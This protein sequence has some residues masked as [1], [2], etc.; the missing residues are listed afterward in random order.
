MA[1]WT[2]PTLEGLT[3]NKEPH[4][5]RLVLQVRPAEGEAESAQSEAGPRTRIFPGNTLAAPAAQGTRS[6]P[7][8][9]CSRK[10]VG[11]GASAETAT[12]TWESGGLALTLSKGP[13]VRAVFLLAPARPAA[14]FEPNTTRVGPVVVGP[15]SVHAATMDSYVIA[16]SR[17]GP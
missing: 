10:A 5:R 1:T 9:R 16:E 6:P 11:P 12:E 15:I 17:P 4:R 2:T 14:T 8:A 13:Q 7:P 3:R